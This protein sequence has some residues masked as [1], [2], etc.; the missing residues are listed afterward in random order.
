MLDL[1][2]GTHILKSPFEPIA[3]VSDVR[4]EWCRFKPNCNHCSSV[5]I[6]P[7]T[8]LLNSTSLEM[9]KL[10]FDNQLTLKGGFQNVNTSAVQ[11]WDKWSTL[12]LPP[13]GNKS[14]KTMPHALNNYVSIIFEF[15]VV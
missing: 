10:R 7:S 2:F 12:N 6:I 5:S 3:P 15:A 9:A 8:F 13:G 4:P 1:R 11:C 14:V